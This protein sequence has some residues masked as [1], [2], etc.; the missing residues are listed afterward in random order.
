MT[1]GL[2]RPIHIQDRVLY[3]WF[4]DSQQHTILFIDGQIFML[5]YAEDEPSMKLLYLIEELPPQIILCRLSLDKEI[6]A[7]QTSENSVT[8]LD[9]VS[10]RKWTLQ[11]RQSE[12]AV[13]LPN[14]ILWSDHGG[15][16]QD[17]IFVT[18]KGLELYKVSTKKSVCKLSRSISIPI[19]FF[20]YNPDCRMILTA[21]QN[22]PVKRFLGGSTPVT[23]DTLLIDGFFLNVDKPNIPSLELPPPDRISRLELGP[24]VDSN[25]IYLVHVYG[26]LLALVQ[27]TAED[28]DYVTV[29][30]VTKLSMEK[31]ATLSLGYVP[32]QIL[33]LSTYDNLL[34]FHDVSKKITIAFDLMKPPRKTSGSTTGVIDPV[35]QP[36]IATFSYVPKEDA[37]MQGSSPSR[38]RA[39]TIVTSY[40]TPTLNHIHSLT[41]TGLGNLQQPKITHLPSPAC[42]GFIEVENRLE[43]YPFYS[44]VVFEIHISG[45]AYDCERRIMWKIE[46]NPYHIAQ[47]ISDPWERMSFLYRRG[48]VLHWIGEDPS[49]VAA[50]SEYSSMM[51]ITSIFQTIQQALDRRVQ[52]RELMAIFR[53]LHIPY[54]NETQRIRW[55]TGV[56]SAFRPGDSD[57]NDALLVP[58]YRKPDFFANSSANS[59]KVARSPT[60]DPVASQRISLRALR[61]PLRESLSR[62]RNSDNPIEMDLDLPEPLEPI[63]TSQFFLPDISVIGIKVRNIALSNFQNERR[64]SAPGAEI[65]NSAILIEGIESLGVRS[66][67]PPIVNMAFEQKPI[68]IRRDEKGDLIANQHDMLAYIWLPLLATEASQ[69]PFDYYADCLTIYITA[70]AEMDL[71]VISAVNICYFILVDFMNCVIFYAT[72]FTTIPQSWL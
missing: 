28:C 17:L 27:Y 19:S 62:L 71:E 39:K 2:T 57:L 68:L 40:I 44:P 34:L 15:N 49:P 20:W 7:M 52:D 26:L 5:E 45:W 60:S 67:S 38:I 11:P 50:S 9:F 24:G 59:T 41:F 47:R 12:D 54:S 63:G 37:Q 22:K 4:D 1:V 70:L 13:I 29:Y 65:D 42:K 48:K 53:A 18:S 58:L 32:Q 56:S 69:V 3:E 10:R 61:R 16:S 30:H 33:K 25:R 8:I 35:I 64:Q 51:G 36:I 46:C 6:L 31:M 23:K 14:G 43:A 72:L 66:P 55:L 21:S